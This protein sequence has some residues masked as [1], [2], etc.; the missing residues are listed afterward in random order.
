MAGLR[1]IFE[2]AQQTGKVEYTYFG[3]TNVSSFTQTTIPF[4]SGTNKKLSSSSPY[5]R[6]GYEG[7]FP[8]D[9]KFRSDDPSG[10]YNSL[11]AST[12]DTARI[13]AFFT[14]FPNGP[15]WLL[16]Q[17]GLQFSNPDTS[18]VPS[19]TDGVSTVGSK[20][21]Q[22][23][24]PRFY[25]PLGVN[26]L[27]SVAGNVLGQHFTR[28]G[29]SPVN[30]EGYISGNLDGQE[31]LSRLSVYK[32]KLNQSSNNGLITLNSYK[33]GPNSF[34]GIGTTK[35]TT[36]QDSFGLNTGETNKEGLLTTTDTNGFIPWTYQ[37]INSYGN[38]Y[39]DGQL[40]YEGVGLANK[41]IQDFRQESSPAQSDNYPKYNVHN[42]IGVTTGRAAVGGV[43]NTVDSI[44]ILRIT[45]SQ[46]F[47]GN[48]KSNTKIPDGTYIYTKGYDAGETL[49]KTNGYYG[50]DIVKFRIEV[51]NNNKPILGKEL[52]TDVIAFRAYLNTMTDNFQSKWNE[53]NYMGR[54]EPFFTYEGFTR[55]IQLTYHIFAH[56]AEEMASLYTKLD[57]LM[58]A[59]TPDY[60]TKNQMRGNYIYLTVGDYIYRQPGIIDSF[61]VSDFFT[62]PWEIALNEPEAGEE[63][64]NNFNDF[65]HYEVPKYLTVQMSFKPIHNFLP[66]RMYSTDSNFSSTFV[67]PNH[68]LLA[69]KYNR[70]LPSNIE[71]PKQQT[72]TPPPEPPPLIPKTTT[73]PKRNP[74]N[75]P[76]LPKIKKEQGPLPD[77]PNVQPLTI[78]KF[79]WGHNTQDNTLV[80][81]PGLNR[82]FKQRIYKETPNTGEGWDGGG[83]GVSF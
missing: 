13:G 71:T 29:L 2:R 41:Y 43:S 53:F 50:R 46:T 52:N 26:T 63:N 22:L 27:A 70:Y 39:I 7:G 16:K 10:T 65:K 23:S 1:E 77:V 56:S 69:S 76:P 61:N 19:F 64:L 33:G 28:H 58:S 81:Q 15:L 24:G 35:V 68:A 12:R 5:I 31:F 21:Q 34:Y 40:P 37:E 78:P 48:S 73:K 62:A 44:N 54:G 11:L 80:N 49:K 6:L 38:N 8:G 42:R 51:L 32:Q 55:N 20:L 17:S 59:M 72:Q 83:S 79:S 30:D 75:P 4:T 18:I 74:W 9:L 25:N 67:T 47:F 14:D 57:Y 66:K 45:P 60:N 3:G 82:N 36:Y